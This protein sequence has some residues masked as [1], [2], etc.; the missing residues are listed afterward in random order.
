MF[1][2][3]TVQLYHKWILF[4]ALSQ[5]NGLSRYEITDFIHGYAAIIT[6]CGGLG[7]QLGGLDN[8]PYIVM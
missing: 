4:L 8:I 7:L 2:V 6:R 1:H 5:G 3:R